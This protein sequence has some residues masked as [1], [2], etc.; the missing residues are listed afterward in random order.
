MGIN[1]FKNEIKLETMDILS[2]VT[3]PKGSF[4]LKLE[5]HYLTSIYLGIKSFKYEWKLERMDIL[6]GFNS[7]KGTFRLKLDYHYLT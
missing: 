6:P 3:C 7:P 4:R 1:S 5:Y 2:D